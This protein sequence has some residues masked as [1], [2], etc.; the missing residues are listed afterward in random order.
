MVVSDPSRGIELIKSHV[1]Y[2]GL[3]M[4]SFR[5]LSGNRA[6]QIGFGTGRNDMVLRVSDPS[7]GIEP[8]K[9][10]GQ[11]G[12]NKEQFKSFMPVQ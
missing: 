11:T 1:P 6:N 8:I 2:L 4:L 9:R 10:H 5:P 12:A 7:R 3:A